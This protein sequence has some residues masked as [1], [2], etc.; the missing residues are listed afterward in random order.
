[1]PAS[2]HLVSCHPTCLKPVHRSNDMERG[3]PWLQRKL[4]AH[5]GQFQLAFPEAKQ[6]AR[7]PAADVCPEITGLNQKPLQT[8]GRLRVLNRMDRPGRQLQG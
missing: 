5:G 8:A 6:L 7:M 4:S 3:E 1:M 2:S